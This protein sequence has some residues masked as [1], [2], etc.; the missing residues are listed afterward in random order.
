MP[1]TPTVLQ[2]VGMTTTADKSGARS[3]QL[4]DQLA[5]FR[6][7]KNAKRFAIDIGESLNGQMIYV[8]YSTNLHRSMQK[9]LLQTKGNLRNQTNEAQEVEAGHSVTARLH[10]V[11]FETRHIE[12]WLRFVQERLVGVRQ[13]ALVG[14]TVKLTG[15]G[16]FKHRDLI[17]STLGLG[18]DMED[19]MECLINGCNFLLKNITD[20]VFEYHRHGNPEY[21]FNNVDPNVFPYLLVNIGSGVS[22]MK[23]ESEDKYER[24]GGSATGGGTFWGLGSLMT[25]AKSFDELLKLAEDGDHRSV[26]MLVK[27]IYGGNYNAMGLTSD[28]I[29]CS[30][31]KTIRF[32]R[33]FSE[34]DI[35]RSLLFMISNDIGQIAS[36]YALMH[37]LTRVYFG[38]YFLR[39]H[40]LSMHT[41]SFA[42]NYWSKGKVRA[43]FLRHEGYLG[44]IGAFLKGAGEYGELW[45]LHSV[46]HCSGECGCVL[47]DLSASDLPTRLIDQLEMDRFDWQLVYC[48]LLEDPA[49]YLADTVDL[50]QDA[51]ARTYWLQCFQD[52]ID[53][54]VEVA[55]CSQPHKEDAPSRANQFK[56]KYLCRLQH[57]HEHPFAYGSLTVRSLLDMREHCLIEFDFPDPYFQNLCHGF[58]FSCLY[59]TKNA[60]RS[61]T[62]QVRICL[63]QMQFALLYCTQHFTC[64]RFSTDRIFGGEQFSRHC[65]RPWLRDDLEPWVQRLR[66]E[67]HRCAAI[68]VD[69]SGMDVVLGVLP[70]ARELLQR[71]TKVLLCANTRPA[72]NDVT[73]QELQILVQRASA[74][75][76]RIGDALGRGQLLVLDSGQSSPCLD[77]SRI[78]LEVAQKMHQLQTDLLVL[79][80]MGR[81]V[82]TNLEA[83]FSCESIKAAVIKNHW[84]AQRLGGAMFSVVF[85]YEAP[86]RWT[87]EAN[88]TV[89][90]TAQSH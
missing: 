49:K 25:K 62:W 71:G 65:P 32:T 84:L 67:P 39:G 1:S 51:E 68:F 33:D 13:R 83:R 2:D 43:S 80:G 55:V 57:L 38:G 45:S 59:C 9:K 40:P 14:N 60:D 63:V 11:K 72:L 88:R 20:E 23:V 50:T 85:K 22:I 53:K 66:G 54:F 16:A 77:L 78:N 44:A 19:E 3:L 42:I 74:I 82:H 8:F 58:P 18:V 5:V 30:F 26:D 29:A 70:F 75:C 10:F 36:L 81:A 47:S 17:A 79:E 35:A 87:Q 27:D 86:E 7:L 34:S 31:G 64:P 69:N 48:P 52:A 76:P 15:G 56:E 37:G 89:D 12:A 4:P 46:S 6:N 28:L 73:F 41:V 61:E 24:I 21:K 90:S